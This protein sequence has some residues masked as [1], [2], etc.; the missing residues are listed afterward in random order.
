MLKVY[1]Q[2]VWSK[3]ETSSFF[4][5]GT[6]GLKF[7]HA[8]WEHFD[9]LIKRN[10]LQSTTFKYLMTDHAMFDTT[11]L[12]AHAYMQQM[13]FWSLNTAPPNSQNQIT[14]KK[15]IKRINIS[16]LPGDNWAWHLSFLVSWCFWTTGPES[17][18]PE[19]QQSHSVGSF[20]CNGEWQSASFVS[21]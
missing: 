20:L 21:S 17:L 19:P 14:R 6:P 12:Y 7:V 16:F 10:Q 3:V 15:N 11:S 9:N 1:N 8:H 2:L 5:W 18:D 13:V 4:A